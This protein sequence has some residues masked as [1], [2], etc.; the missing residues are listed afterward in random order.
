VCGNDT[1]ALGA[2]TALRERGLRVP[3]DVA[4]VGFDDIPMAAHA[5]PPLTTVRSPLLKMGA[6]AGHLALDL[7]EHGPRRAVVRT[8]PTELV[9]RSSCG[10]GPRGPAARR[11]P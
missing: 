1:V 8:H 7:I 4:V 3:D 11:V 9:V 2:L 5:C 6:A 10:R